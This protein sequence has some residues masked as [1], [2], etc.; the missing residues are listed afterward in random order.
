[1]KAAE[2]EASRLGADGLVEVSHK[3]FTQVCMDES[4]DVLFLFYAAPAQ[5]YDKCSTPALE[6]FCDPLE[7]NGAA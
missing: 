4:K 6:N 1:M 7:S 5:V 3:T 2:Q